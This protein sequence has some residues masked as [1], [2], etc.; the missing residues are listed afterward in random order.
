MSKNYTFRVLGL[1][2][3]WKS[4]RIMGSTTEDFL[5][6]VKEKLRIPKDFL[7]FQYKDSASQKWTALDDNIP[8]EFPQSF[9]CAVESEKN[10]FFL[11]LVNVFTPSAEDDNAVEAIGGKIVTPAHFSE[12]QIRDMGTKRHPSKFLQDFRALASMEV[13]FRLRC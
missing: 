11:R 9:L 1:D 12:I 5:R 3:I 4:F 7:A 8:A 13:R 10:E 6:I 2:G